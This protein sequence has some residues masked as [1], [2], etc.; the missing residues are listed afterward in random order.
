MPPSIHH[1]II[2]TFFC[3]MLMFATR[4]AP[5]KRGAMRDDGSA[6]SSPA[7]DAA[8]AAA[9]RG[10]RHCVDTERVFHHIAA[11]QPATQSGAAAEKVAGLPLRGAEASPAADSA[12]ADVMRSGGKCLVRRYEQG[13][14]CQ[15]ER[16]VLLTAR[17]S[18]VPTRYRHEAGNEFTD[19]RQIESANSEDT[20]HTA[21]E[22]RIQPASL[23]RRDEST[24]QQLRGYEDA[25]SAQNES[26]C[27]TETRE[28][29]PAYASSCLYRPST[30]LITR[31][32]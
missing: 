25:C 27:K 6:R 26:V 29:S 8:A 19:R 20:R 24:R 18:P 30:S 12:S 5:K 32:I 14:V 22:T 11:A 7:F 16:G 2:P 21:V 17:C 10:K 13:E 15:C 23:C 1:V 9:R 28:P 3:S 4:T 31:S